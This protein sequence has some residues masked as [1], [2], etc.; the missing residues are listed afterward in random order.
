LL[1]RVGAGDDLPKDQ[2]IERVLDVAKLVRV[3]V[4]MSSAYPSE[5]PKTL[6]VERIEAAGLPDGWRAYGD[7]ELLAT[8]LAAGFAATLEQSGRRDLVIELIA[9]LVIVYPAMRDV[10]GAD[11]VAD[12]TTTALALTDGVLA[13]SPALSPRGVEKT[14]PGSP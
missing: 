1:K 8:L 12:L 6:P 3:G 5:L 10:V 4:G 7:A 14:K 9:S 2:M 11:A 13:S